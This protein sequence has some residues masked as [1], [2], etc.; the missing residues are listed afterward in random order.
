MR[1][2]VVLVLTICLVAAAAVAKPKRG[3]LVGKQLPAWSEGYLDIHTIST[4]RGECLLIVMPDGTSMVVD[5]GELVYKSKPSKKSPYGMALPRPNNDIRPTD[6]YADYIR[7]FMPYKDTID[8]YHLSHFH[9]DHMGSIRYKRWKRF[10]K[11]DYIMTGP[12]E[13]YHQIPFREA[14]DR[15][16]PDY[17]NSIAQATGVDAMSNYAKFL[18]YHSKNDGMKA[19]KFEL[20]ATNQFALLHNPSAYPNFKIEN[21][22]VNGK[23]WDRSNNKIINVYNGRTIREN[24]SSCGFVIRYGKFDFLTAGDIG[25][26]YDY[27]YVVAKAVGK[28]DAVKAH[29]HLSPHSMNEKCMKE[30]QPQVMSVTSFGNREIQ[31]D[32]SKLGFISKLGCRMYCTSVGEAMLKLYPKVYKKCRSVSGHIVFRVEPNGERFWVY[33]LDDFDSEYRIKLVDGPLKAK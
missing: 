17:E 20:G 6:V 33:V 16:Y 31:P 21:V 10:E 14:N 18:D 11:G 2:V 5:A 19:S 24:A 4:G 8:Y 27:E 7:N 1:R 28:V 26:Y 29:H 3:S 30:L 22:C 13:L 9:M 23:V 12:T 32:Q 15:A 25:D